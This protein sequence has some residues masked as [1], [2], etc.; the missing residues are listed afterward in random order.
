VKARGLCIKESD[1]IKAAL[2][3]L[4][5]TG[6]GI[7][8]IQDTHEQLTGV[9]TDGDIRRGLIRGASLL[10]EVVTV[11]NRNFIRLPVGSNTDEVLRNFSDRVRIIPL[12]NDNG[13]VVDFA[14][15]R[16]IRHIPVAT[17]ILDGN[18]LAYVT[19]CIKTSWISSQGRFVREFEKSFQKVGDMPFSLAVSNGTVALHLGLCALGIGKG[20]EVIIPDLTF[21]ASANAVIHAGGSPVFADIDSETWTLCPKS[22][23]RMITPRTRAV[24]PVHLY[25]HPC[26]MD[27][28]LQIAKK[29]NILVIEDCAEALGSE[30]KGRPI[31]SFGDAATFSFFGNKTITTGEGGML[32]LRDPSVHERAMML[33]DHGMSRQRKYWHLEAGFNYR[34]TNLQAALGVAQMERLNEFVEAKRNLAA[35][36]NSV[37]SDISML[38]APA[39]KQWAKNSYWLYTFLVSEMSHLDHEEIMRLLALEG[40]E[41]RPVFFPMHVMPPYSRFTKDGDLSVS[42]SVSKTGISLPS[43]VRLS[44]EDRNQV[45]AALRKV[46]RSV[47][48]V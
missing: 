35:F 14:T 23:E 13:T 34:M 8:F 29:H 22:F 17:P 43:S 3:K 28:I 21:A 7:L 38:T 44:Y 32:L 46:M 31:G 12:V 41:T 42:S 20:D 16:K 30:Y 18:E 1:S 25:G 27:P 10:D 2:E 45:A 48:K 11:M 47:P 6:Q 39:E 4:D 40:I 9:L 37:L 33:R 36:Y 24:M 5:Q 15:T 26:D 19:E